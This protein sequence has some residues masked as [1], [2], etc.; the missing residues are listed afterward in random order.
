MDY[1]AFLLLEGGDEGENELL[2]KYYTILRGIKDNLYQENKVKF[3]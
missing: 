3:I 1:R 2:R